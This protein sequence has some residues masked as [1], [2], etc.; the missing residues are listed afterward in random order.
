M[1]V[2]DGRGTVG[3]PEFESIMKKTTC[4]PF[5]MNGSF[6]QLYFG[7]ARDREVSLKQLSQVRSQSSPW[8]LSLKLSQFLHDYHARYSKYLFKAF[9]H[10]GTGVISTDDF[11][12]MIFSVKV[13]Y[14]EGEGMDETLF[15]R[16]IY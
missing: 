10:D 3:F 8:L 15:S 4:I 1:V 2:R 12:D 5:D 11:C 14:H 9:D 6:T 7:K 13:T 16:T